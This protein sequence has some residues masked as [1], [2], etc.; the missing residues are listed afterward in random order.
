[1]K[2]LIFSLITLFVSHIS[3][4]SYNISQLGLEQGLTNS[5]IVSITQDR[6]GFL[7]FAT[8]EGLNKFDGIHF[9]GHYK[10]TQSISGNELNRIYADKNKPII[11]IATQRAG[12][13]A[14]NYETQSMELFSHEDDNPNSIITNDITDIK[15]ANGN[16]L[17]IS[18]FHYGVD[19]F[20]TKNKC[21]THYNNQT[22]PSLCSNKT[23]TIMDDGEGH[24]YIGHAGFGMSILSLANN[25]VK[26]YM[27]SPWKSNSIPGNDVRCIYKDTHGNIWIGTEKGLSIFD[28]KKEEFI[29][30]SH[31]P[32][33]L[34]NSYVFD[35]YQTD[36]DKLWIG[37]ELNGIFIIDL[38]RDF[39]R[40]LEKEMN[41]EHIITSDNINYSLA[42]STV[43]SI[44][45]DEFGNIWIG[46][47]GG[48]VNFI[49]HTPPLFSS[50]NYSPIST[51]LYS[52]N[53]RIALSLC[54]GV[55]NELWIGTDGSGISVFQKGLRT[56][57]YDKKNGNLAHNSV[58]ALYKDS[59]NNI[60]IGTFLGGLNY[61]DSK[62]RTFRSI[63]LNGNTKLD[64]RCFF[65]DS[66][67]RI[68]VG[69][70]KGIFVIDPCSKKVIAHYNH[71]KNG[72]P[73]DLIRTINQDS[74]GKMW[75]GTFGEGLA[76][77]TPDMKEVARF[78]SRSGFCSNSINYIFKDS[79]EQMW[80]ATGEGLVLFP[81]IESAEYIVY[82]REDGLKN[83]YI[84]SIIEDDMGNIWFGTNA[85]IGCKLLKQNEFRNYNSYN[86]KLMG[87]FMSAVTKDSKG[88]I[89]MGSI[90]GVWKFDPMTV[91]SRQDASECNI[92][93]MKVFSGK[94]LLDTPDI[95]N[96]LKSEKQQIKLDC[97]QNTFELS[98]CVSD[99]SLSKQVEYAY[100]LVGMDNIWYTTEENNAIFRKIPPGEYVFQVK[101]RVKYMDWSNKISSLYIKVEPPLWLTWW[102]ISLYVMFTIA[103]LCFF[104]QMYRKWVYIQS[105]YKIM[106]EKHIH[107]K[108]LN[109]ERLNFYTNI[110]HE[111]R[112][113]LTLILGP[114]EDMQKDTELS[115]K[116]R[117]RTTVIHQSALR[118]LN[119]INQI[120][121]FRKVETQN[122][123]LCVSK[124]NLVT[125][126]REVGLK[127]E[128]LSR[129]P[130]I[131]FSIS[132]D[133]EELY[134]FFDKEIVV[135]I[136]DNLVSNAIKYTETG[137]IELKLYTY[138]K[139]GVSYTCIEVNDTG[140]GIDPKEISKIFD[141]YY[142]VRTKCQMAGTGIG[143]SLVKRLVQL[144]EGEI[145]VESEVG[146][147]SR[148][149][150]TLLTHNC[151]MQ[152]LHTE[153]EETFEIKENDG[154]PNLSP[155]KELL[156]LLVV[157]DN[158][159][160]CDYI[161]DSF[162]DFFNVLIAQNG[163]KGVELAYKMT[164]DIIV[165]DIMMPIM[166]GIELCKLLKNN[167]K[168]SHIPIILLTAKDSIQN[169]EDGYSVGA[170]SYLTKPFS[171]S[172]LL[173]RINNLMEAQKRMA[174]HLESD[175][176]YLKKSKEL[177]DS[178]N[179]LDNEF[180]QQ[181]TSLIEENL[182]SQKIDI[183]YLS[184]K[185]CMS[186]SNLY[187]KMKALTG[188]STNEFVRKI[189]LKNAERLLLEGKYSI[190]EVAFMV[191][192]NSVVYFRACFKEEY[193]LAPS[194]YLKH[195]KS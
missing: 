139:E 58:I 165:S 162:S 84:R 8:E 185:M 159:D 108:E 157:E 68:W 172:L 19:L 49:S 26:N 36:D 87:S 93:K 69:S 179:K 190:S 85:G 178:L 153:A 28:D 156:T 23:W 59:Y 42:N 97:N 29:V 148:F 152:A 25:T 130:G 47:Y 106:Q 193:G 123:K 92:T 176:M 51:D 138:L 22:L 71:T 122:K 181:M 137:K 61:Y 114:L 48:G 191:G 3:A 65:E 121:E 109:E 60:W 15:P 177:N 20:D 161:K 146:K 2:F 12:L 135:I 40:P 194:H 105:S 52:I 164:P 147:G 30:P 16:N 74:E 24:L 187:R 102:A 38:K 55:D 13:N 89:Y 32:Q 160:L 128:E 119:L 132:I 27:N 95:I 82:Q 145:T 1:M 80:I 72:L 44:F 78:N 120:L 50:Y 45:Q 7:W 46:T 134:M 131:E 17:W 143:L 77:Y 91:L 136:L 98:F 163:K 43:R 31:L 103:S 188:L 150:F 180:L 142:Q 166:D 33:E 37:T 67:H 113:P 104:L 53:N 118:L 126:I 144:H 125:L 76:V 155:Q 21:F 133:C 112:T 195:L 10:Y 141:Q 149:C 174:I 79:N 94:T 86:G 5:Y 34:R 151:Y 75:I 168:T 99:Y 9:I 111:L 90:D 140:Y 117:K 6:D 107:E 175:I 73:N 158:V 81:N 101:S 127:Y 4:Q 70:R 83:L 171:A 39:L 35:I 110:A 11:W 62:T 154:V 184:D 182:S 100:R 66:R 183:T 167:I 173:C 170:D 41:I 192:M 18:T 115:P 64:V 96:Y 186:S 88:I 116:Q 124:G 169:K 54:T 63:E 189:K 14:Y 57:T 56:H 129:K